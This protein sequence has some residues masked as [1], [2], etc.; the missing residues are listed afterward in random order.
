MKRSIALS[1]LASLAVTTVQAR[2]SL[3]SRLAALE[4]ELADVKAQLAKQKKQ[5]KKQKRKL[6]E[7]RAHDSDDNIKWGVDLRTSIDSISYD[8]V[9]G[10]Q[11]S[12]NDLM[13]L[14]LWL[15]MAFSP[16]E[17]NVFKGQLSMNKAFGADFGT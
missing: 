4:Q 2:A 1:I 10:K 5:I 13:G 7:V 15:N 14:R 16:D 9:D 12:K 17:N 8:M 3:E 6:N 11:R